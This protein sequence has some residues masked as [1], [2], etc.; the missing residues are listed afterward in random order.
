MVETT[1]S[2]Q[3]INVIRHATL[4]AP[5]GPIPEPQLGDGFDLNPAVLKGSRITKWCPDYH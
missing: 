4:E 3:I 2:E 5:T 1:E